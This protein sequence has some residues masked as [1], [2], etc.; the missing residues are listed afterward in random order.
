MKTLLLASTLFLLSAISPTLAD[1]NVIVSANNPNFCHLQ[2]L[3]GGKVIGHVNKI[4]LDMTHGDDQSLTFSRSMVVDG[5]LRRLAF[6]MDDYFTN[7]QRR[8]KGRE[9]GQYVDGLISE[10]DR[11]A[12]EDM[13]WRYSGSRSSGDD[14]DVGGDRRLFGLQEDRRGLGLEY[15]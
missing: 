11:I 15:N 7:M 2:H 4:R 10:L 13:G 5:K 9:C 1:Y 14:G 6:A 3:R 12:K 8:A